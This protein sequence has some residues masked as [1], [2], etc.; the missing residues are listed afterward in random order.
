LKI[1]KSQ[2][3]LSPRSAQRAA[4]SKAN[5]GFTYLVSEPTP[6]HLE[7][8]GR[9]IDRDDKNVSNTFKTTI[10]QYNDHR[11][12]KVA[13]HDYQNFAVFMQDMNE[14]NADTAAMKK[15]QYDGQMGKDPDVTKARGAAYTGDT[16]SSH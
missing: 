1:V 12:S 16:Y 5:H 2:A 4:Q 3:D 7:K 8:I 13:E 6:K 11:D 14:L 10:H 9:V 15:N